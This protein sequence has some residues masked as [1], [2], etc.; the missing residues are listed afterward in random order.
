MSRIGTI[1]IDRQNA[2]AGPSLRAIGDNFE[3]AWPLGLELP[4]EPV[5]LACVAKLFVRDYIVEGDKA[6]FFYQRRPKVEI[7]TN[8]GIAMVSVNDK[9]VELIAVEKSF[10][11]VKGVNV[12]RLQG[13]VIWMAHA[14]VHFQSHPSQRADDRQQCTIPR[15][16]D[17]DASCLG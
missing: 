3:C 7:A 11:T 17:Q 1:L 2:D 10:H 14:H 6:A 12:A 5:D 8:P 13:D 4:P 9:E 16:K 15:A